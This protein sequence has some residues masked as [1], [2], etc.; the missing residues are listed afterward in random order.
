[1][2]AYDCYLYENHPDP[3]LSAEDQAWADDLIKNRVASQT[4]E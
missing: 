4:Q 1:M 3:P 2:G